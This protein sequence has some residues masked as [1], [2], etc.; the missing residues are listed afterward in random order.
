MMNLHNSLLNLPACI[1]VHPNKD[2]DQDDIIYRPITEATKAELNA[3][4]VLLSRQ[5]EY[6]LAR[7]ASLQ[8]LAELINSSEGDANTKVETVLAELKPGRVN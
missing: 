5:I 2:C 6:G 7:L 8:K 4:I 3:Y 1:E